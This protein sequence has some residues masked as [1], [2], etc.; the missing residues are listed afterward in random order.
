MRLRLDR[1]ASLSRVVAAH[2]SMFALVFR[3]RAGQTF[4]T[5]VV[6]VQILERLI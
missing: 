1:L 6:L 4:L 2:D 3:L 5:L